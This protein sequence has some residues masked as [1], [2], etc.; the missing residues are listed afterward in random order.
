MTHAGGATEQ[1]HDNVHR[2]ESSSSGSTEACE[3]RAEGVGDISL[4]T[5]RHKIMR[6]FC[7]IAALL[8][9]AVSMAGCAGTASMSQDSVY[10]EQIGTTTRQNVDNEVR[11]VLASR[12]G[13]RMDREVSTQEDIRYITMWAEH[14]PLEDE[15]AEGVTAVR[16]RIFVTARPKNRT[17][18]TYTARFRGECEVRT[19]GGGPW[20]SADMTEMREEYFSDISDYLESQIAGGLRTY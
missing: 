14:T 10:R 11:R 5:I 4:L 19:E 8:L 18:N 20:V 15:R 13:Y 3:D 6:T 9:F 1:R 12:Y 16:T 17:T 7:K 2:A